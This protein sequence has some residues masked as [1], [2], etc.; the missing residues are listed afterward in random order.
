MNVQ[1]TQKHIFY[2]LKKRASFLFFVLFFYFFVICSSFP[3]Q[4]RVSLK[5][6]RRQDK[7]GNLT[8]TY[9]RIKNTMLLDRGVQ[10]NLES[11]QERWRMIMFM[12]DDCVEMVK[13][14][15]QNRLCRRQLNQ[16]CELI[17]LAIVY[18]TLVIPVFMAVLLAYVIF[19]WPCSFILED[20]SHSRRFI[21]CY[22]NICIKP[23]LVIWFVYYIHVCT[24][25]KYL[26]TSIVGIIELR[27]IMFTVTKTHLLSWNIYLVFF[28]WT[29]LFQFFRT[30]N[31]MQQ[32]TQTFSQT[33]TIYT[34]STYKYKYT[35]MF[36]IHG[37]N[38][39]TWLHCSGGSWLCFIR[40]L[41][42]RFVLILMYI[43]FY[44]CTIS[45]WISEHA[46]DTNN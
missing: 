11:L 1:N 24:R 28:L 21:Q 42:Y 9:A 46:I 34:Y 2:N 41:I 36:I 23:Y 22:Q 17:A 30:I 31:T 7:Y 26:G 29:P 16:K 27:L 44:C 33:E 19:F 18:S 13:T 20:Y 3:F 43:Q 32:T 14:R 12:Y 4:R 10:N 39:A 38:R 37:R 35:Y 5:E 15:Q 8:G 45:I 6:D 40:Q 25:T